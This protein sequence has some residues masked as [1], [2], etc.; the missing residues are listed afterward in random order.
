[1]GHG[2]AASFDSRLAR[3]RA[4]EMTT[5]LRPSQLHCR[6]L[7][8]EA[9]VRDLGGAVGGPLEVV[10]HLLCGEVLLLGG[11]SHLMRKAGEILGLAGDAD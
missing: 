2:T 8:D 9:H 5:I 10:R 7:V 11:G 1:M 6:K 4:A 3:R